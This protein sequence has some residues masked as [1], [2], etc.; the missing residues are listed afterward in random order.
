MSDA[1]SDSSVAAEVEGGQWLARLKDRADIEDILRRYCRLIDTKSF[2][3]LGEVFTADALIDYR[4]AGGICDRL[5]AVQ[6]W[7][8]QALAPFTVVQHLITNIDLEIDGATATGRT[9]FF[10]PMALDGPD[11]N[12]TMFFCGGV[13]RDVFERRAEGWRIRERTNDMLYMHGD[14]PE[15]FEVPG[16][17]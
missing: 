5:P 4:A 6:A 15:G 11:G 7:L 12:R 14:L 10:N 17:E 3:D 2:A 16:G 9:Y 13:Y 1:P 8:G